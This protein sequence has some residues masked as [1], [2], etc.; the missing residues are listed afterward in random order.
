MSDSKVKAI[1]DGLHSITPHLIC[2]RASE[3]IECY[4][5]AFNVI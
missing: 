4:E 1:P 3:A 2:D 5:K